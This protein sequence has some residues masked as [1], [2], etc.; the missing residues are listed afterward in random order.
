L[1][2]NNFLSYARAC[3]ALDMN[4][5]TSKDTLTKDRL[6]KII[7]EL[8]RTNLDLGFLVKLDQTELET[9]VASVRERVDGIHK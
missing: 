7:R 9:L 3:N 1:N 8:L 5:K 4:R 6:I 2:K